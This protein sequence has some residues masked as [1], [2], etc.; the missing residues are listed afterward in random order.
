METTGLGGGWE[1]ACLSLLPCLLLPL[2]LLGNCG[3]CILLGMFKWLSPRWRSLLFSWPAWV[4]R[5]AAAPGTSLLQLLHCPQ[6]CLSSYSLTMGLPA[7]ALLRPRWAGL[8]LVFRTVPICPPA[9]CWRP[10]PLQP[11]PHSGFPR[12]AGVEWG[13]I[14]GWRACP[15]Q[16]SHAP[17]PEV[18][19]TDSP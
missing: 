17:G 19:G 2:A 11:A 8:D 5:W 18:T 13:R 9:H 1:E 4:G 16:G 12:G 14:Q 7:S 15:Q 10:R 3:D 6:T